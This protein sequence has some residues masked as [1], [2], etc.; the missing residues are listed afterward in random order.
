MKILVFS[1]LYPNAARPEHGVFVENRLTAFRKKHDAEIR[2][3]A[4]VPW[5]PFQNETFGRYAAYARAPGREVR[6]EIAVYHPRFVI[7]PKLGMRFAPQA[8]KRC[9]RQC[10]REMREDGWDFDLID[11]HYLYPDGVA[12]AEVAGELGKPL[13]LTARGT[14]VNLIPAF[15][16]PRRKILKAA[17]KADAVIAVAGALKDELVRLGVPAGKV[18]VLRNGVDLNVFAPGDRALMRDGM[19]LSGPV[20]ASVGQLTA[21]KGHDLVIAALRR[22]P[23]ATLLIAGDGEERR[24]L[25]AQAR[26][27]GL[28]ARVRFLGAL[29]H[30]AL[31]AVYLAADALVLASSREGW[32][33]VLLEAMACG[34]PCVAT[35]VWGSAEVIR[36]PAAGRLITERTP[37]AIA[38]AANELLAAPPDRAATRAYAERHGWDETVD[39]MAAIFTELTGREKL[40][41]AV[42]TTPID[43]PRDGPGPKL[44]VT[45]DTEENADWRVF[46]AG[47]FVV[48]DMKGVDR[49]QT[50]CARRGARPLYF[51]THPL[52]TDAD[53]AA[54][55]RKL[56]AQGEGDCGLHLHPWATPPYGEEGEYFSFQSN[57]PTD[58]LHEK[59]RILADAFERAFG[60]RAVAHRAG[61]YGVGPHVY[62]SLAEIGVRFDFSP[63][64]GF[65]FSPAGGPDFSRASNRPTFVSGEAWRIAVTPVSGARALKRTRLFLSQENTAKGRG[66]A[67]FFP[68]R[69][70]APLRLSP[71]G[72]GLADLKALTRTL[73]R[74][75]VSVL[76]F[77]LHSSSLTPGAGPYAADERDVE[78]MLETT[79]AYLDWFAGEMNGT[80]VSLGELERLYSVAAPEPAP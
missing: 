50:I 74:D 9:F 13:V 62:P 57:L 66:A 70:K 17:A 33:N 64:P 60:A 26:R 76:T 52:L 39:A 20:I 65:D 14:D 48:S 19:G 53:A 29:P 18:S 78:Q 75:K 23:D 30:E 67:A 80:F 24:A 73:V 15:A 5:F 36:E 58:R 8:L 63:N 51:L 4:P 38:E 7:P 68:G 41:Q 37:E 25:E 21:R 28:K 10:A 34:T 32:P 1:T 49:F 3:V 31:R 44:I 77:T 6:K 22:M 27:A 45:V 11:A 42:R 71:E 47:R 16:A 55:F 54:Y 46:E 79:K 59:L 43:I 69:F 40:R 56:T 2:V 72:A 12:A 61:R 35:D